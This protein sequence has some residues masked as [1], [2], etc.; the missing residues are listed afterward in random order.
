MLSSRSQEPEAWK[1]W[2]E[3]LVRSLM[4]IEMLS[5]ALERHGNA[6]RVGRRESAVTEK[7]LKPSLRQPPGCKE[8]PGVH[9]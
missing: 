6:L 1:P 4:D 3:E 5:N 7:E 8:V 9:F 2:Y